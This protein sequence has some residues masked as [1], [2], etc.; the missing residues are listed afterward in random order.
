MEKHACFSGTNAIL[1]YLSTD[2]HFV[3]DTPKVILDIGCGKGSLM[4]S[5]L[6]ANKQIVTS[7]TVGLDIFLP[8]LLIAKKVYDNVLRC[9]VKFLPFR[10]ATFDIVISTQVIEHL[11]KDIGLRLLKDIERISKEMVILTI[12]VDYN[13]K[14]HLEDENPWQIHR[15]AWHPDEFKMCGFSVYGYA[16]PRFLLGEKCELKVKSKILEPFLFI[17]RFLTQFITRKC[18]TAS[19]QMLCIKMIEQ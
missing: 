19:Y 6:D 9:D 16:G 14:Q 12:P 5:L 7:F 8:S 3:S 13:E 10:K 2:K 11:T 18:V 17:L 15:S 4:K 1:H